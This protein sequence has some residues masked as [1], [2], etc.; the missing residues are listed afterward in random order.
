MWAFTRSHRLGCQLLAL[1]PEP[2]IDLADYTR[3]ALVQQAVAAVVVRSGFNINV[4]LTRVSIA[5][6]GLEK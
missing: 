5:E 1:Q 6:D 2:N 4:Y 3:T